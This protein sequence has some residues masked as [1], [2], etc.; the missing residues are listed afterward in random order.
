MEKLVFKGPN[1]EPVTNSLMIAK[2]F[3]LKHRTV[4]KKIRQFE[5]HIEPTDDASIKTFNDMFF[6][7]ECETHDNKDKS[8]DKNY[9]MYLVSWGGFTILAD[10]FNKD[11]NSIVFIEYVFAFSM[12]EGMMNDPHFYAIF[13]NTISNILYSIAEHDSCISELEDRIEEL[14]DEFEFLQKGMTED[15]D[16]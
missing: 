9:P 2:Q 11:R 1:G 6:L 7:S 13:S 14:E 12:V 8:N 3:G 16:L 10:V 4:I 5:S 15:D